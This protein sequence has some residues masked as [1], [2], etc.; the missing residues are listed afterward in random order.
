[1][2][3][4]DAA[5]FGHFMT[6]AE[7]VLVRTATAPDMAAVNALY[8]YYVV[9]SHCTYDL[10]PW[11]TEQRLTWFSKMTPP[12]QV[13]VAEQ[14]A[15]V[16]GFAYGAQ[17]RK[18]TGYDSSVETTVYVGHGTRG[19]GIGKLLMSHLL[20]SLAKNTFHRAYAGI[21]LPNEPSI[22]LHENLGYRHIGTFEAVGRKF[23]KY[24]D[25]AWYQYC[26][27]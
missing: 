20:Q 23:D 19:L 9:N 17:H 12:W 1:M 4:L 21:C 3:L 13:C 25:V 10:E 14:N 15:V 18:K 26:F 16:L 8:N 24:H 7:T 6:G 22:A 5:R 11:S 27:D 2:Q